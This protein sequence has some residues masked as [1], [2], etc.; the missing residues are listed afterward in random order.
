M[1]VLVLYVC[2]SDLRLLYLLGVGSHMVW[3]T[4]V[5]GQELVPI[6]TA[7]PWCR[8]SRVGGRLQLSF[9]VS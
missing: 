4:G 5:Y 7:K 9:E 1:R 3:G 6:D 2:A 8:S